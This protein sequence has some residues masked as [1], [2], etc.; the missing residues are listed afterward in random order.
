MFWSL[1]LK[2]L[3][4]EF[5]AAAERSR[6]EFERDTVQAFQTVKVWALTRAKKRMPKLESLLPKSRRSSVQQTTGQMKTALALLAAQ[7]G[8]PLRSGKPGSVS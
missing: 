6:Q 8:F 4:W 1:T 7:Y 2:E 5:E 3:H